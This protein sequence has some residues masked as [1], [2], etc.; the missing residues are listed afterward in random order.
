MRLLDGDLPHSR[1]AYA[2]ASTGFYQPGA[3]SRPSGQPIHASRKIYH[4]LHA[5]EMP[6]KATSTSRLIQCHK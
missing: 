2:W 4:I 1:F 5:P 3:E 6:D